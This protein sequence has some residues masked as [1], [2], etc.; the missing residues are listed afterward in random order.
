MPLLLASCDG[1]ADPMHFAPTGGEG[2]AASCLPGERSGDD[3]ECVAAGQQLN[4]C[5]A[6]ETFVAEDGSCRVA[7]V[8]PNG[9]AAGELSTDAGCEEAGIPPEHCAAGFEA[10]G[11]RGCSPVLP[12]APCPAGQMAAVGET[13]CRTVAP[14][15][16]SSW[17]GIPVDGTTE[18]VDAEFVGSSDGTALQPW[19]TIQDG[20]D[21]A[22][23]GAVVAI[24]AGN[25]PEHV[26]VQGKAVRLWGRCPDLVA[27]VGAGAD[28]PLVAIGAGA[29]GTEVRRLAL[30]GPTGGVEITGAASVLLEALWLHDLA[31]S[32]LL[33]TDG[34]TPTGVTLRDS[35]V[36]AAYDQ[37]VWFLG[38]DGTVERSVIRDTEPAPDGRGWGICA[39]E[40][41][42]TASRARLVLRS[43]VIE[44]NTQGAVTVHAADAEIEATLI[45]NTHPTPAGRFGRGLMVQTEAAASG[46]GVAVVRGSVIEHSFDAG[47]L[48]HASEVT[49]EH[50][51]VRDTL[52]SPADQIW[53]HGVACQH[54]GQRGHGASLIARQSLIERNTETGL[55]LAGS[56]ATLAGVAIRD[57]L[58]T[59][60][61]TFGRGITVQFEPTVG[62]DTAIT[63]EGSRVDGSHDAGV[64]ADGAKVTVTGSLISHTEPNPADGQR[65]YGLVVQDNVQS[66]RPSTLVVRDSIIE[67]SHELGILL[68]G[69]HGDFAGTVVRGTLQVPGT[70]ALGRGIDLQ[71]NP[72]TGQRSSFVLSSCV[73]EDNHETGVAIGGAEGTIEATVVGATQ[74]DGIG[75]FG[76]GVSVQ[77]N[78]ATGATASV[79]I[80]SSRLE[81]NCDAGIAVFGAELTLEGTQVA[82]TRAQFAAQGFGDGI[83][84]T[85]FLAPAEVEI[86]D[87]VVDGNH[88]AGVAAF[89]A[90]VALAGTRVVCNSVDLN[91]ESVADEPYLFVDRGRNECGCADEPICRVLSSALEVPEPVPME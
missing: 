87:S 49:L 53:G 29:D 24:A 52:A 19:T 17:H 32:A 4:G 44:R 82:S 60:A 62:L 43:S 83:A 1:G 56:T 57:S 6:G 34:S 13:A 14:C 48:V 89:S 47:I 3:G 58:P 91:G 39:E 81:D 55:M 22:A 61:D 7:G 36:E 38:A 63:L 2:G 70:G 74:P 54:D 23:A 69:S 35:L 85:T 27:L 68:G 45:R 5:L 26:V 15:G 64:A 73:V 80:R 71:D 30:H 50:T 46:P 79:T 90:N 66:R 84:A 88:R 41:L 20:V 11:A 37:A 40:N 18:H 77:T 75:R 59:P 76:R 8:Q 42:A 16:T 33:A 67:H 28:E 78:Q 21:A 31:G 10:D 65:G 9:C 25:Y 12:A 51:V 86:V 72:A